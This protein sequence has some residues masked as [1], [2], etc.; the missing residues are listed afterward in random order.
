MKTSPEK[1]IIWGKHLLAIEYVYLIGV[2][3]PKLA[4]LALYRRLF[5]NKRLRIIVYIL[6]VIL[7]G[8][9]ISTVIVASVACRPYAANWDHK[10]PGAVCIDKEAF[11][12]Y[13]SLPNIITDVVMLALPMPV[14][15]KLHTSARMKVGLT[16]TFIVGSLYVPPFRS[17][18]NLKKNN[19]K[20]TCF[21]EAVL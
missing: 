8:L 21:H 14:V 12:I 11:F 20:L 17:T 4:I 5:P 1:L 16:A 18:D 6:A 13:S 2:N 15:W 3:V 10:L 7:I 9:I 19:R